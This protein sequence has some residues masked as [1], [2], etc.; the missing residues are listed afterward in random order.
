M[1]RRWIA[2]PATL[3]AVAAWGCAIRPTANMQVKY[4][5]FDP[6]D[7]VE[8]TVVTDNG[9]ETGRIKQA[10]QNWIVLESPSREVWIP[11]EQIR[12]LLIE[13]DGR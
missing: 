9:L 3:M 6:P 5:E 2:V 8:V 11:R 4:G 13:R 7:G 10:D 1:N 12:R